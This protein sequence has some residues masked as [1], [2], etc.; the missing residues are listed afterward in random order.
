M[1]K[2]KKYGGREINYGG[3]DKGNSLERGYLPIQKFLYHVIIIFI[4][5]LGWNEKQT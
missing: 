5:T 4:E 3:V 1:Y 2:V